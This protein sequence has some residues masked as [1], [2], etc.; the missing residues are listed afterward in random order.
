MIVVS[1]YFMSAMLYGMA[2]SAVILHDR[3]LNVYNQKT[4][5]YEDRSIMF[6]E[7]FSGIVF[8][9]L[10]TASIGPLSLLNDLHGLELYMRGRYNL[11]KK[12]LKS[13]STMGLIIDSYIS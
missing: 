1:K 10:F 4:K 3:K 2:R 9:T 6:T 8:G 13:G 11:E 12:P 5:Q 7:R